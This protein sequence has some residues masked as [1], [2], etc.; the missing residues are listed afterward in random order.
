[1]DSSSTGREAKAGQTQA[2]T[3][4]VKGLLHEAYDCFRSEQSPGMAQR[5]LQ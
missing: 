2:L 4:L 3:L 1:M 5:R